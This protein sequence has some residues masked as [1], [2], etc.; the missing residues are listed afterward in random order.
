MLGMK[1]PELIDNNELIL[2]LVAWSKPS[3]TFK[4]DETFKSSA[5]KVPPTFDVSGAMIVKLLAF[6]LAWMQPLAVSARVDASV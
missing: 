6:T 5:A 4:N 2:E 1:A 3:I